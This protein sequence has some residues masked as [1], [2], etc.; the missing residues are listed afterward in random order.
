M[1]AET[2]KTVEQVKKLFEQVKE[3]GGELRKSTEKFDKELSTKIQKVQEGA[4]E[5]VK[6]IEQKTDHP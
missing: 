3:A 6:H 5:V 1:S 4:S 2:K